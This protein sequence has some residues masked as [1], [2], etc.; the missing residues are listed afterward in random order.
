[1][2]ELTEL[3]EKIQLVELDVLVLKERVSDLETE[4]EELTD[5]KRDLGTVCGFDVGTDSSFDEEDSEY[6]K[7]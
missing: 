6:R 5:K 4:I 1:M 3:L 2:S 7:G